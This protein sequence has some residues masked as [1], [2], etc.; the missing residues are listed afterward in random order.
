MNVLDRSVKE[1]KGGSTK[2]KK[3]KQTNA[4]LASL[5]AA[6]ASVDLDDFAAPAATSV[7]V[8]GMLLK[9]SGGKHR[10]QHWNKRYFH[11]PPKSS[12][13]SYY[14]NEAAYENGKDA[15]GSIEVGGATVFQKEKTKG[16][17]HRFTIAS[18][19]REL[20]LRA[21]ND[22]EYA[23]WIAAFKPYAAV[24]RDLVDGDEEMIILGDEEASSDDEGGL[25]S[26]RVAS[27]R[28]RGASQA[29]VTVAA[30][31]G[32]ASEGSSRRSRAARRG[33]AARCPRCR[34]AACLARSS[35]SGR[36]ATLPSTPTA[37]SS[38]G[39]GAAGAGAAAARRW[40]T[41]TRPM[42]GSRGGRRST[43]WI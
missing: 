34:P 28:D 21:P 6:L 30:A 20:K 1:A 39:A 18:S 13:L 10:R 16:G 23:K 24:F 5:D 33:A 9:K 37:A 36:S 29:A 14:K 42:S 11:L 3:V 15:L 22:E 38:A 27:T 17:T 26:L 43:R 2:S 19:E 31:G 40:C 7:V 25:S 35:A 41:T 8:Q 32:G 12:V 4:T